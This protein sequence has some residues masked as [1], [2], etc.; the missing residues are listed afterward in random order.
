MANL[1]IKLERSDELNVDEY[2]ALMDTCTQYMKF[3]ASEEYHEDNDWSTWIYEAAMK[4]AY[5]P[6]VWEEVRRLMREQNNVCM[7]K[8][9]AKEREQLKRRQENEIA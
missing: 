4:A 6:K 7:E 9:H 2:N 1:E 3:L 8:R 5:G